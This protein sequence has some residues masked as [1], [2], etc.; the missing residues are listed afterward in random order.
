MGSP[1]LL[2]ETSKP[3]FFGTKLRRSSCLVKERY[4][5]G[6]DFNNGMEGGWEE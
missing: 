1:C 6:K 5:G 2:M 3:F 4:E